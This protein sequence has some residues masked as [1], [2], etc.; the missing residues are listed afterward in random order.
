MGLE[1]CFG[2]EFF[3]SVCAGL[4]V[5]VCP[6]SDPVD[7]AIV[8]ESYGATAFSERAI[9]VDEVSFRV[10]PGDRLLGYAS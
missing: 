4:S 1:S 3:A 6:V 7:V 5:K 9:P 8:D 2:D 10:W